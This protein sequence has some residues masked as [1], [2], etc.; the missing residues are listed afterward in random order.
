VKIFVRIAAGVAGT[1]AAV[2]ILAA[3]AAAYLLFVDRSVPRNE[4]DVIV[5]SGATANSI[6]RQ[7]ESAGVIRS[8]VGFSALA[9]VRHLETDLKAGE[10]RFPAHLTIAEVLDRVSTSG[11]RVAVWVTF[12]EG[13]TAREI[14]ATLAEHDLGS[15]A[16]LE[17][18]FLHTPLE[19]APGVRTVN[20]EGYLFPN[21]YLMPTQATPATLA[22]MM[23]DQFLLQL[24]KDAA[25]RAKRLK[26][27]IPEIVTLASL[28]E[29]EAKADDERRLMASVYY[30][31]LH[32][33]MPLQV[34]ATLEYTFA[35]HKDVI[36]QA[37]LARDTPYNTYLHAGLPPTPIANPGRPSLL[38][39]FDPQSSDYLFYVYKGNGHH[40]FSRTLA[41]HD[42]NVARYLH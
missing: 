33:N 24:P 18:Y 23:T 31:R 32:R 5:A 34:D 2:A 37:D 12:P 42:A 10:Y 27:S 30:N 25:A 29:R 36:T 6:A 14:A 22:R 17:T 19:L 8:A 40:A 3:G 1:F 41:E 15:E 28:V 7:L 26:L 16:V 20:L 4:S 13:F 35:H 38:A 9:R 39:A 11:V 21:T